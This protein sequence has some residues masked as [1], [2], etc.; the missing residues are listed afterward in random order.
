VVLPVG[1]ARQLGGTLEFGSESGARF[2]VVIDSSSE[3]VEAAADRLALRAP[4]APDI[5]ELTVS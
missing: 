3:A 2:R 5:R 4:P 1:L